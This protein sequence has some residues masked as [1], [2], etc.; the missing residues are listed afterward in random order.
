MSI[1]NKYKWLILVEGSTDVGTFYNLFKTYDI[2]LY[3]VL[4]FS[5]HGKGNVCNAET[6]HTIRNE[7]QTDLLSIIKTDIG[8]TNFTGIILV[9]DSDSDNAHAFDTYKRNLDNSLYVNPVKPPASKGAGEY[10]LLDELKGVH[11]IPVIGI[12][13]PMNKTGCL[14]TDLLDAY[15]FPIEGQV[16]YSSIVDVIEKSSPKWNIPRLNGGGNWWDKN[17]KAKLDKFIYSALFHGF[18]VC[19]QIPQLTTEPSVITQIKEAIT[20][21]GR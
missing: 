1:S 7:S 21:N 6:W 14:E 5:A 11:S 16:E 19:R 10:W 15:G 18:S 12:N 20:G 4:L 3:D 2:P 8:R 9:V 13:I 17:K